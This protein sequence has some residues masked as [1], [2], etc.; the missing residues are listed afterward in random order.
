MEQSEGELGVVVGKAPPGTTAEF[1]E[2]AAI[3]VASV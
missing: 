2:G 3:I 1:P